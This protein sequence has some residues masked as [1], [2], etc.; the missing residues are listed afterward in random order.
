MGKEKIVAMLFIGFAILGIVYYL[1]KRKTLPSAGGSGPATS[2]GG[3]T[4]RRNVSS[5]SGGV[6]G[7]IPNIIAAAAALTGQSVGQVFVRNARNT[8]LIPPGSEF[9]TTMAPDVNVLVAPTID[10]IDLSSV[11][12]PGIASAGPD[13]TSGVSA[14]D[15]GGLDYGTLY[16]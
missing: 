12:L 2:A 4:I 15:A 6:S 10:P 5:A 11:G 7:S 16:A 8:A 13:V 9:S 1:G 14:L 3:A